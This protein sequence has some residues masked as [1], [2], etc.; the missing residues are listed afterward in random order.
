MNWALPNTYD[1]ESLVFKTNNMGLFSFAA[2]GKD[3][4]GARTAQW[5]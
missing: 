1:L 4:P 2:M 5:L 3:S